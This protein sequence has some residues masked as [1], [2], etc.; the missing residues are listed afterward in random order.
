M[1]VCKGSW[2][3]AGRGSSQFCFLISCW[4]VAKGLSHNYSG[5]VFIVIKMVWFSFHSIG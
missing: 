1:A 4:S 5:N 3:E 2:S